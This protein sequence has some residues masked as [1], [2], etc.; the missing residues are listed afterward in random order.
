MDEI[1]RSLH[2][3]VY[4]SLWGSMIAISISVIIGII[5]IKIKSA[6]YN[7]EEQIKTVYQEITSKDGFVND[8]NL[9]LQKYQGDIE[10]IKRILDKL[11]DDYKEMKAAIVF[12]VPTLKDKNNSNLTEY[13]L[14]GKSNGR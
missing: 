1:L 12:I 5:T 10:D 3:H 7:I 4:L 11:A 8:Q 2:N 14:K 6:L 13:Q 9:K